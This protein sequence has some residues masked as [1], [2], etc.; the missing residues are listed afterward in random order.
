[1][2]LSSTVSTTLLVFAAF[3]SQ[4]VSGHGYLVQPLAKFISVNIDKTQ[5]SSTIDSYKL[6]PG[7]T[8]NT[9]PTINIKSFV[10]HFEK[11]KYKSIKTMIEDKQVLVSDDAT[12][13]CG[14]SSPEKTSYGALNDTVYWGRNDDITQDEGLVHPGPCEVWCDD[15]RAQQD[16]NCMK[17]Y[18]PASGKGAAPIPIDKS[19]CT[20]AKRL[21]FFWIG[22]HGATWQV[23]INCVNI[24]GGTGGADSSPTTSQTTSDTTSPSSNAAPTASSNEQESTD[25][26]PEVEATPAPDRT[27]SPV[28]TPSTEEVE[29]TPA[30]AKTPTPAATPSVA[31]GSTAGEASITGA[32]CSRRRIRG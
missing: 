15:N 12:A 17:T 3:G 31:E 6:F 5:Y 27:P 19:V 20:D 26:N 9:D 21:T 30:P 11:S 13:T 25:D 23:Y 10:E 28:V 18:T 7:G 8:F 29:V 1:M 14:F 24:N 16:M 22:M 2:K 4:L 32:K